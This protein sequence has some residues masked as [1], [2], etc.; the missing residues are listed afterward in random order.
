MMVIFKMTDG[1]NVGVNP[2]NIVEC[3]GVNSTTRIRYV[4]G[5]YTDVEATFDEVIK[6]LDEASITNGIKYIIDAIGNINNC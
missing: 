3:F 5:S 2:E 1:R 6:K 4:D